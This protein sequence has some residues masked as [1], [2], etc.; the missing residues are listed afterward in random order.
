MN[1]SLPFLNELLGV[2]VYVWNLAAHTPEFMK[3]AINVNF[4]ANL[5]NF[6]VYSR[7]RKF[8]FPF[9]RMDFSGGRYFCNAF[10]R[11]RFPF[12][13]FTYKSSYS[14]AHE[15]NTALEIMLCKLNLRS[16]FKLELLHR[17]I[18]KASS[19]LRIVIT[20]FKGVFKR[21]CV[22]ILSLY[23]SCGWDNNYFLVPAYG[24]E[25][26]AWPL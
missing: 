3:R 7:R 21:W 23:G 15:H 9:F 12:L 26:A 10:S 22:L 25:I 1:M 16:F 17:I 24:G 18:A 11:V 2:L 13:L 20:C 4:M 14:S 8:S 5:P 19:V 6:V